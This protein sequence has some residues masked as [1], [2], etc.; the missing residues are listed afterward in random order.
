[1]PKGVPLKF[2]DD[3]IENIRF[4]YHDK[5]LIISKIAEVYGLSYTGIW[6][7]M[8]KHGIERRQAARKYAVDEHCFDDLH[9]E[10]AVY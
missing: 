7:A 2:T 10:H 4:L 9:D 5:G 8:A 3:E 6:N 1:M